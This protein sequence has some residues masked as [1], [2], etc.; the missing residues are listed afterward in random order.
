MGGG[1]GDGGNSIKGRSKQ[2]YN[3]IRKILFLNEQYY[4]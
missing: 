1:A 3:Y 2:S 4:T